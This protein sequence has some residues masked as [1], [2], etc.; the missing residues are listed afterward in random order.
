MKRTKLIFDWIFTKIQTIESSKSLN[1]YEIKYLS[2]PNEGLSIEGLKAREQ[3]EEQSL[4]LLENK[5][6]NIKTIKQLYDWFYYEHQLYSAVS[7]IDRLSNNNQLE[8]Y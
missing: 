2:T 6:Q 5:I 8:S 4:K 3:R 7:K 1:Y